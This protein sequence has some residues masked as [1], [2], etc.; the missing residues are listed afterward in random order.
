MPT[1]EAFTPPLERAV[2]YSLP[3]R[4]TATKVST[5]PLT[6]TLEATATGTAH[7]A[8]RVASQIFFIVIL[9]VIR[10]RPYVRIIL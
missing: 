4:F 9:L 8:I 6:V 10:K 2:E 5:A 1:W 3:I 7:A